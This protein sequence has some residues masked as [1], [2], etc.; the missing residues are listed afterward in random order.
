MSNKPSF[1][2]KDKWKKTN[3]RQT[4][5]TIVGLKDG[6]T[7]EERWASSEYIRRQGRRTKIGQGGEGE[8]L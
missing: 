1:R 5:L 4:D 6:F 7:C 8:L 2:Q 3:Y